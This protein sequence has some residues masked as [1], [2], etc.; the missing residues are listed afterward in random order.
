MSLF[1]D[2]DVDQVEASAQLGARGGRAAHGAVCR[3]P[4]GRERARELSALVQAGALVVGRGL[5]L[6]A[7]HGLNFENVGPVAAIDGMAELNIGHSLV[8]RAVLVGMERAV[9]EMKACMHHARN[10]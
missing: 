9:R 2:P 1:I 8:S 4:R 7:G 6:H 10:P 5:A 3:R